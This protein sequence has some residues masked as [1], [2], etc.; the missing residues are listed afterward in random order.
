MVMAVEPASSAN[1]G[2]DQ[3]LVGMMIG[4]MLECKSESL[5]TKHVDSCKC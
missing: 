3:G 5:F 2:L 4:Q 1:W